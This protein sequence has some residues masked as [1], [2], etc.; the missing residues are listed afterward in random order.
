[1]QN[2]CHLVIFNWYRFLWTEI[3]YKICNMSINSLKWKIEYNMIE[4]LVSWLHRKKSESLPM[5]PKWSAIW[6]RGGCQTCKRFCC[7][8]IEFLKIDR[9]RVTQCV[10]IGFRCQMHRPCYRFSV[11]VLITSLH[12]SPKQIHPKQI[13][14]QKS[15]QIWLPKLP[16]LPKQTKMASPRKF[17]EKSIPKQILP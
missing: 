6:Y 5:V 2:I 1:M 7:D 10:K 14:K 3:F 16:K 15:Y 9:N 12:H 13:P 11:R 8:F 4:Y 17:A